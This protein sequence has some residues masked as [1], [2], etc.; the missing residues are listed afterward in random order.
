MTTDTDGYHVDYLY[1]NRQ[2]RLP[3][4]YEIFKKDPISFLMKVTPQKTKFNIECLETYYGDQRNNLKIDDPQLQRH[5]CP[6]E[7]H[8]VGSIPSPSLHPQR[9]TLTFQGWGESWPCYPCTSRP[10]L[11]LDPAFF[12]RNSQ[13]TFMEMSEFTSM[14]LL[15]LSVTIMYTSFSL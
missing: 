6:P 11:H 3:Y 14:M 15:V 1:D 8:N 5:L 4:G 2:W 9:H 13:T 10:H 12:I 7:L